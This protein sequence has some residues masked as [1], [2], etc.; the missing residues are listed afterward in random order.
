MAAF[1]PATINITNLVIEALSIEAIRRAVISCP[2][3]D[4]P[5]GN[6]SG[7]PVSVSGPFISLSINLVAASGGSNVDD[8]I[9]APAAGLSLFL[10]DVQFCGT[11]NAAVNLGAHL[12]YDRTGA[13]NYAN[14]LLSLNLAGS[15][16]NH[17][18]PRLDI[19][20]K[21]TAAKAFGVRNLSTTQAA[22]HLMNIRFALCK[23]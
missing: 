8:V 20:Q 22:A 9:S 15:A 3:V 2:L 5:A 4:D 21:L 10:V 14:R 11:T 6:G 17:N 13:N 7:Y 1:N 16:Q 12:V 18:S 23:G 19:Y